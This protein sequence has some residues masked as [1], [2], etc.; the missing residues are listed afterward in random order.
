VYN[1][2]I[3]WVKKQVDFCGLVAIMYKPDF[4][5]FGHCEGA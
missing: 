5:L 1:H 2:C 3:N 4:Y